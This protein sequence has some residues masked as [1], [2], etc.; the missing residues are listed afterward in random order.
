MVMDVTITKFRR[1]LFTLVESALD[2]KQVRVTHK[3]R[4]FR[5]VPEAEGEDL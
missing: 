3:G 4:K 2:G 5:I 1:D